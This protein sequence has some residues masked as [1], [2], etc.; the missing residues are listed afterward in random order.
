MLNSFSTNIPQNI[1]A[2]QYSLGITGLYN[3]AT[4]LYN[5]VA[6]FLAGTIHSVPFTVL[7]NIDDDIKLK[8]ATRKFIRAKAFIV[9]PL[10]MG[11]ILV[12][13]PFI[14]SLL[15]AEWGGT[16]PILQLLCFGGLFA[17]LDSSNGD[18]LRVKGKSGKILSLEIF[19]NVLILIVITISLICNL[20][21]LYLVGGLSFT[22]FIKYAMTS[23]ISNKVI[24][25]RMVELFK[26]LFPYFAITLLAVLCGYMLQY[27]ISS[28]LLLT[29]CQIILVG[30]IY[31]SIL[32]FF[33]SVIVREAIGVLKTTIL[34]IK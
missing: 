18:L 12:S 30:L 27:L 13:K 11:M 1:I 28:L 29:I 7:S 5:T 16:V 3:Q 2:K 14:L 23:Y 8:K 9:F 21:Y 31:I 20:G 19:R 25:Y 22:Y 15:G 34:K 6:D 17:S 32:Y 24:Q 10:F 26:D 33:G 4:K